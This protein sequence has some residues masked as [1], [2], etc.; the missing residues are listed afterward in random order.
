MDF[1]LQHAISSALKEEE[2][3]NSG[4]I[5]AYE[6][7][8]SDY[9]YAD[10][11]ELV[12]FPD[13]HDMDRFYTQVGHD[14]SLFK[15]GMIYFATMRGIP[16]LYYGT[17]ILMENAQDPG[18]HGVIRT[19][20]PGGWEGDAVNA[21][22][23]EGLTAPQQEAQIVVSKL[24]NWRKEQPVIH[25]GSLGCAYAKAHGEIPPGAYYGISISSYRFFEHLCGDSLQRRR[26]L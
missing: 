16:Q 4:M 12:I 25:R 24:F 17:E 6:M 14:M 13:N 20:F 18:D 26:L 5:K 11:F 23:G 8:S 10:P 15:M 7:L 2:N 9:L 1:P 3:W 22:S 21:F 19:D